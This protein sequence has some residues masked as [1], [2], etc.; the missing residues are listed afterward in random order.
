MVEH[1]RKK[2]RRPASFFKRNMPEHPVGAPAPASD[3]VKLDANGQPLHLGSEV[4]CRVAGRETYFGKSINST[5][6]F[7]TTTLVRVAAQ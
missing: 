2:T 1:G 6:Q 4:E 5:N 3:G 7:M